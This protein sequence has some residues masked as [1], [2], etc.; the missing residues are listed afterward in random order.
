[1]SFMGRKRTVS[2][3]MGHNEDGGQLQTRTLLNVKQEMPDDAVKNPCLTRVLLCVTS[4]PFLVGRINS[5]G[6]LAG[7]PLVGNARPSC[8]FTALLPL[9]CQAFIG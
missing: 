2:L 5:G 9:C 3:T 8:W 7:S 4:I 1:M 6:R